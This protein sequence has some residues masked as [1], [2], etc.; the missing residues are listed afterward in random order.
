MTY[1]DGEVVT[2]HNDEAGQISALTSNK[3]G[4]ESVI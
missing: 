2:Y 4:S 3:N 1:P